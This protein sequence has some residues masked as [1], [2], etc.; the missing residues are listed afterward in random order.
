MR[1]KVLLLLLIPFVTV[2]A[3]S[4]ASGVIS[5]PNPTTKSSASSAVVVA[6][7]ATSTVLQQADDDFNKLNALKR[8]AAIKEQQA[9]LN[10]ASVLKAPNNTSGANTPSGLSETI[11][12]SIIINQNGGSFA[13]LQFIDGSSLI[14]G[15]GD[16]VG[17]YTVSGI[18]MNGVSLTS[19]SNKKCTKPVLIK[20]AYPLVP[21]K[22]GGS[23]SNMPM[24]TQSTTLLP[25]NTNISADSSVPPITSLR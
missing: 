12:T 11:A 2:Y 5:A 23:G 13:T 6:A 15:L 1:N 4:T 8:Q 7:P 17:K 10:G 16:K 3:E 20:R 19:C 25:I 24:Q 9:K 18:N 22:S 14:V 21:V